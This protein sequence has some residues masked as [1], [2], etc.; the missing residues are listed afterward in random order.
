MGADPAVRVSLPVAWAE[1][2]GAILGELLGSFEYVEEGD[3]AHLVFYPFRQGAG[4]VSD[5]E[6]RA[7]LPGDAALLDALVIERV[8][9]P[10]GWEEGWKDHFHPISLGRLYVRPPWAEPPPVAG[11][12]LDIVLTPGLAFGTGLHPTTRGMLTLLQTESPVGPVTDVGTGSGILSIAAGKLGF[13]PV[14]AFDNDPLAVTAA[15]SNAGE[16]G[17]EAVVEFS[18][19]ASAPRGWFEGATILAN[20]TSEPVMALI[21]RLAELGCRFPRLLV[22]GILAGEQEADVLAAAARAGLEAGE[23]I[24]ETEWVSMDLRPRPPAAS[25]A[26]GGA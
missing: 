21:A 26:A 23:R 24:Y 15:R 22:S 11:P 25:A 16:N 1:V 4:Y 20:L 19:V 5:E 17:V 13:S 10:G 2:A 12:D 3:S 7:I 8:L 18:D 6:I 14:I 9:V